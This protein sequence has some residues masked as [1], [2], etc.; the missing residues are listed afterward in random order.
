MKNEPPDLVISGYIVLVP[1]LADEHD[2]KLIKQCK[3]NHEIIP[4]W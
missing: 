1:M 3:N 2:S 4:V